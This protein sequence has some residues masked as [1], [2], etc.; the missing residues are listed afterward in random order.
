MTVDSMGPLMCVAD[1]VSR[2]PRIPQQRPQGFRNK[3]TNKLLARILF[4]LRRKCY[5]TL[6]GL[7]TEHQIKLNC[8]Y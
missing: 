6:M 4:L 8:A 2:F 5:W 3:A 1:E 7:I